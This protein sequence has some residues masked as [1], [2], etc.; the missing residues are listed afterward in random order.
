M[1]YLTILQLLE[2]LC[3]QEIFDFSLR[4]VLASDFSEGFSLFYRYPYAEP[5][6]FLKTLFDCGV[7]LMTN[8]NA[9]RDPLIKLVLFKY[10][11]STFNDP[12]EQQGV[13][14]SAVIAFSLF[15]R[16]GLHPSTKLFGPDWQE[17]VSSIA[18]IDP[19][20]TGVA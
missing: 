20:F 11:F 7:D 19:N 12:E 2:Y 4:N 13:F 5:S 16:H 1:V 3:K 10:I 15:L 8:T 18:G 6:C 9:D 14:N 17:T